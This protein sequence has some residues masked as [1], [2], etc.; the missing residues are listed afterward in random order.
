M[1]SFDPDLAIVPMLEINSSCDIPMPSSLIVKVCST[2]FGIISIS[3]FSTNGIFPL[4]LSD[5]NLLL[6]IASEAFEINSL[7][8]ISLFE[9]IELIIKFKSSLDSA[10]N[11]FVS[12]AINVTSFKVD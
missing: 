5:S 10:W 6:S 9:Y 7:K 1:N 2:L 11:L 12:T 3:G 4:E 8:K